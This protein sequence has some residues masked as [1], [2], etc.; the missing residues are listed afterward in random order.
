MRQRKGFIIVLAMIIALS[1]SLM[2][3]A[4]SI[5]IVYRNQA[6][7]KHINSIKA[8]YIANIGLWYGRYC[9]NIGENEIFI[10][11]A[12]GRATVTVDSNWPGDFSSGYTWKV[13]SRAE[14]GGASRTVTQEINTQAMNYAG[15][16]EAT[17]RWR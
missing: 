14:V 11:D 10:P 7:I 3:A 15:Y 9:G 5:A 16:V 2:A 4:F 12:G 13:T 17:T 8:Y 6:A 1:L